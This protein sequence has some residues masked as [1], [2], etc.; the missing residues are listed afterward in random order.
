MNLCLKQEINSLEGE[1]TC[2]QIWKDEQANLHENRSEVLEFLT[3]SLGQRAPSREHVLAIVSWYAENEATDSLRQ[4][5]GSHLP[6]SFSEA[7][8]FYFE[9]YG[10][11]PC[12]FQDLRNFVEKLAADDEL[13]FLERIDKISSHAHADQAAQVYLHEKLNLGDDSTADT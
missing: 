13:A 4:N 9:T 1:N 7:C 8:S 2:K 11:K 5:G 10:S 3:S 12:C 6:S